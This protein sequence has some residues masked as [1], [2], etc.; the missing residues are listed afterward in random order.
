MQASELIKI[1]IRDNN[2]T[3]TELGAGINESPNDI[4]RRLV[5]TV[6]LKVSFVVRCLDWLGYDLVAVSKNNR[7]K[8]G[9][10]I[11]PVEK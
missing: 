10:K 3:Q 8:G 1:L 2:V 11:D 5:H 4:S 9:Y 7:I 6:D